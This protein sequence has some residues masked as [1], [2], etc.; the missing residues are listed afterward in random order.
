M[1]VVGQAPF[2]FGEWRVDPV[3]GALSAPGGR[4]ARLEPQLMDLL[5]LFAGSAGRVL[6]KDEIVDS[7]WGGRAIGDDTLAAAVSRLR[8]TLGET[9]ERRYIETLPKRGY[10]CVIAAPELAVADAA[11]GGSRRPLPGPPEAEA[12]VAQGRRALASPLPGG[13][14]QARL[15]FEAAVSAAPGWAVAHQG[16]ADTL[17]ARQFAGQGG[18]GAAAAKAAAHAAVG[19][20]PDWANGWATLGAAL[21]L[22]DRELAPADA[23]LRRALALAPDSAEAHYGRGWAL[24]LA[25]DAEAGLDSLLKGLAQWGAD[26]ERV[27]ALRTLWTTESPAAACAAAADLFAQQ[28]LMYAHRPVDLAVLRTMANQPDAAFAA[29]EAAT[30]RDHPVLLLFP[31]LPHFDALKEDARYAPFV[32]RLRRVR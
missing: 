30:A 2:E 24:V 9:A 13:L 28:Q 1:A 4:T 14:A 12:L 10:R 8:R 5:V 32:G 21:L 6:S 29:L 19:L 15:S 22:A 17:I 26:A 18:D 3:S 16:L 31:W 20:A 11:S 25:G 27:A 7:A 23:A